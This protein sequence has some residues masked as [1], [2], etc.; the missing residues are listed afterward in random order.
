LLAVDWKTTVCPS[1]DSAG[2]SL[3]LLPGA[4]APSV[5]TMR[6]W[7]VRRSRQNTCREPPVAPARLASV[8]VKAT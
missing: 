5:L 7:P 2:A 4:P 3:L 6:T 8:E 1:A